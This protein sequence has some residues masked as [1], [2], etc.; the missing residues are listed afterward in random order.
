[1]S[2]A[3]RAALAIALAL[4]AGCATRPQ[5]APESVD[6]AEHRADLQ[7]VVDYDAG[8]RLSSPELDLRAD[9][10]IEQRAEDRFRL[11]LAGPLGAGAVELSGDTT[12][13]DIRNRDGVH[14]T[15]DPERWIAAH[16]GWTLPI[17][18]LKSWLL[19]IPHGDSA[20]QLVL[21]EQGRAAS[22]VQDGWRVD[23]LAYQD[24][25]GRTLPRRIKASNGVVSLTILVDRWSMALAPVASP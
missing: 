24:S 14:S 20:D 4:L 15:D 25:G 3:A 11:R 1:M 5:P 7:A 17:S 10:Q 13:V 12:R 2:S 21:D 6:W 8:G 22:L 23:Y 19:G 9:F 16:Y 18:P